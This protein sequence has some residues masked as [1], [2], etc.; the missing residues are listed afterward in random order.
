MMIKKAQKN[1]PFYVRSLQ[2]I[3]KTRSLADTN[4]LFN[5][6]ICTALVS[7]SDHNMSTVKI[8]T[9]RQFIIQLTNSNK[10]Y[11]LHFIK[12]LK[13]HASGLVH[14]SKIGKDAPVLA[15][16]S[17]PKVFPSNLKCCS[18]SKLKLISNTII[19]IISILYGLL[20]R[21]TLSGQNLALHSA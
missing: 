6:I 7:F 15:E 20:R 9:D 18:P 3:R 1:T 5:Y 4:N 16:A 13:T 10:F 8:H 11:P 14:V 19:L 12:F 21:Q 17:A 2:P